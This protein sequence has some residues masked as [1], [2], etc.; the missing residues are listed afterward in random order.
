MPVRSTSTLRTH[1]SNGF[2]TCKTGELIDAQACL[3]NHVG[4]NLPAKQRSLGRGRGRGPDQGSQAGPSR[5]TNIQQLAGSHA[6]AASPSIHVTCQYRYRPAQ[7]V[8]VC[9]CDHDASCGPSQDELR[10]PLVGACRPAAA[11]LM[12]AQIRQPASSKDAH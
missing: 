11:M 9:C 10:F 4:K 1:T 12:R 8:A 3:T 5:F 2:A 6:S 7:A